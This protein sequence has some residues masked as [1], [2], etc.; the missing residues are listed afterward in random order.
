MKPHAVGWGGKE[1]EAAGPRGGDGKRA[2][3]TH[4]C[5]LQL[6]SKMKVAVAT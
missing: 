6:K 1:N 4:Y 2:G 3:G 5:F